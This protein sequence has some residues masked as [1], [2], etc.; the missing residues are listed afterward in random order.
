MLLSE[1][2]QANICP[3]KEK[4]KKRVT[5]IRAGRK[6]E[7]RVFIRRK[8]CQ[9]Q[10]TVRKTNCC[11]SFQLSYPKA[12]SKPSILSGGRW[13]RKRG[14]S[15]DLST[16][17]V[18]QAEDELLSCPFDWLLFNE[19]WVQFPSQIQTQRQNF[20]A[21]KQEHL[22]ASDDSYWLEKPQIS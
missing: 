4:M 13:G 22:A 20:T 6:N 17:R 12:K 7:K 14:G 2:I 3:W 8:K 21:T 18:H 9:G 16:I 5:E 19:V 10:D 11:L 15:A 1:W